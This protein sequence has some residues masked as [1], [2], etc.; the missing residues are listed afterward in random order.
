[1][2]RIF[3]SFDGDGAELK[4]K[5]EEAGTMQ[6]LNYENV[7]RGKEVEMRWKRWHIAMPVE[8]GDDDAAFVME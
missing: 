1:M 3:V 2:Y 7:I 4:I 5:E 6:L 8:D